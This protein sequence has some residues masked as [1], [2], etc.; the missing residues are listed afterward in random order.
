M[1]DPFPDLYQ[2]VDTFIYYSIDVYLASRT[3]D[4]LV[5]IHFNAIEENLGLIDLLRVRAINL[6]YD[7]N[8]YINENMTRSHNIRYRPEVYNAFLNKLLRYR[9]ELDYYT[10]QIAD[11]DR[12]YEY[13]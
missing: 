8:K 9:N 4:N 11:I 1:A 6:R 7:I 13:T 2:S 3:W 10:Q 5:L 12:Q